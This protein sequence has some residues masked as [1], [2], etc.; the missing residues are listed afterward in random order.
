MSLGEVVRHPSLVV[1]SD[2]HSVVWPGRAEDTYRAAV[3]QTP[4]VSNLCGDA[5]GRL[6]YSPGYKRPVTDQWL[7]NPEVLLCQM[8]CFHTISTL[9]LLE[10]ITLYASRV[11]VYAGLVGTWA[12]RFM[13]HYANGH[14]R[15]PVAM[16]FDRAVSP[17][18]HGE[19]GTLAHGLPIGSLAECTIR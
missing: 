3:G 8:S 18:S 5:P 9:C 2:A 10:G 12:T 6:Q 7:P 4:V 11:K 19:V 17:M 16:V 15:T 14:V 13:T 1:R